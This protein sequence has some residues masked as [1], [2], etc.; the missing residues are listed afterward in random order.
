M[1]S[2]CS[3][4]KTYHILQ[5]SSTKHLEHRV[6]FGGGDA[7]H[8]GLLANSSGVLIQ[9]GSQFPVNKHHPL[10]LCSD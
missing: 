5:R 1:L 3:I 4:Y 10:L 7:Q 2:T 6:G 9:R 8:Y